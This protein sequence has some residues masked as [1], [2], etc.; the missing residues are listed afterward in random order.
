M[1]QILRNTHLLL[2]LAL[3]SF[4]LLFGVSSIKFAHNDWFAA[5]PVVTHLTVAID[6]ADAETPRALARL[7]MEREG[8]RGGLNRIRDNDEG[9]SFNIGRMG[10][11]HEVRYVHGSTKA[12]VEK[13]RWPLAALLTWMHATFGVDHEYPLHN[14]WGW[15][16]LL[17]SIGLLGLGGSGI[18]LW[19]KIYRERLVGSIL[20]FG[21]LAFGVLLV[22]LLYVA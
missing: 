17:T 10:T 21:N 8:Y 2:G 22:L 12:Q 5:E 18:Y 13:R 1:Y 14:L 16:M 6:P 15:L 20:L 4:V 11:V 7:L 9:F 19:F 3:C